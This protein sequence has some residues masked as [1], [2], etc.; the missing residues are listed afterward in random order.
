MRPSMTVAR[1]ETSLELTRNLI[2]FLGTGMVSASTETVWN[3]W[4]K[5]HLPHQTSQ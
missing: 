2:A 3:M 4:Q 1:L 5:V